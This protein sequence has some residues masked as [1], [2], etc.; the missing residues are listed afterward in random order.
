MAD[1]NDG[2]LILHDRCEEQADQKESYLMEYALDGRA[3]KIGAK[4]KELWGI[5]TRATRNE[6]L[7]IYTTTFTKNNESITYVSGV[8]LVAKII[9][10]RI[11]YNAVNEL[12]HRVLSQQ[13]NER[14]RS[15]AISYAKDLVCAGKLELTDT[16]GLVDMYTE[17]QDIYEFIKG[18]EQNVEKT[19]P[20]VESQKDV[21]QDGD[22]KPVKKAGKSSKV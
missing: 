2:I 6:P 15:Q 3:F 13:D 1:Y 11:T 19:E 10:D 22:K 20:A 7:L 21:I 9:N 8:E 4:R 5:F 14:Y 16:L 12:L 17:A 18:G